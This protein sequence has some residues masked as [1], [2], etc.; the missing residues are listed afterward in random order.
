[1]IQLEIPG[2]GNLEGTDLVLDINGT[3]SFD[4]ALLPGVAARCRQL[5]R[6][7]DIHLLTADTRGTA[8]AIAAELGVDLTRVQPGEEA[9]Q[10]RRFVEQLGG[11]NV[12]AI[13]NGNND[14]QM[15]RAAGLGIAV[16]GAEGTATRAILAADIVARDI[17]EALDLL[18]QPTRILATL[19]C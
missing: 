9:A 2:F 19:R 18:L 6:R 14:E 8:A 15:L 17:E 1:M 3:L 5:A 4:G 10:K 13:G 7:L 16:L 12:I 11:A